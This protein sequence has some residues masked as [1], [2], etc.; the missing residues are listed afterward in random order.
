MGISYNILPTCSSNQLSPAVLE[1]PEGR[2][3]SVGAFYEQC[4]H[5]P[6]DA[7]D[8]S[9]A[10]NA[11]GY[12]WVQRDSESISIILSYSKPLLVNLSAIELYVLCVIGAVFELVC[13]FQRLS[14]VCIDSIRLFQL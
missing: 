9:A 1:S 10:V 13:I 3:S 11:I 5:K 2:G 14:P 8:L 4:L 7:K 6:A 12:R